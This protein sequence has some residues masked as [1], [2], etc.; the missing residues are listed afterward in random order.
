M[1]KGVHE[2]NRGQGQR[3]GGWEG[4]HVGSREDFDF[5][6]QKSEP[7][8]DWSRGIAIQCITL[9]DG[10]SARKSGSRQAV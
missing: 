5:H 9:S 1:S 8:E 10:D 6:T 7:L 2:S 3:G 4:G